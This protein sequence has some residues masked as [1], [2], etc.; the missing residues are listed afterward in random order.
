MN[1]NAPPCFVCGLTSEWWITCDIKTLAPLVIGTV[2]NVNNE[3]KSRG[4]TYQ[5][6]GKLK[7]QTTFGSV[8]GKPCENAPCVPQGARHVNKEGQLTWQG[9][10]GGGAAGSADSLRF[11]PLWNTQTGAQRRTQ[12]EAMSCSVRHPG[13]VLLVPRQGREM[14]CESW[15]SSQLMCTEL[16][17]PVQPG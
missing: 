12:T 1:L 4:S 9:A 10:L 15:G 16:C 14:I 17:V 2:W 6:K 7:A 8:R 3:P 5:I 13:A 11:V